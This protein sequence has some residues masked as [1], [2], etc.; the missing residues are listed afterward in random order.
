MSQP[1]PASPPNDRKAQ[2]IVATIFYIPH[3]PNLHPH[4]HSD[5]ILTSSSQ[6]H[7]ASTS[8]ANNST[9]SFGTSNSNTGN[10]NGN[11]YDY[12]VKSSNSTSD[13]P[14]P[15]VQPGTAPTTDMDN[16]PLEPPTPGPE[17]LDHLYGPY[18]SAT[19]LTHFYRMLAGIVPGFNE[20]KC[21]TKPMDENISQ[22]RVVEVTFEVP[23][24]GGSTAATTTAAGIADGSLDMIVDSPTGAMS[25]DA[26]MSMPNSMSSQTHT[27]TTSTAPSAP[28]QSSMTSTSTS[29]SPPPMT[30]PPS[31]DEIRRD[32]LISRFEQ[33]WDV[34]IVFQSSSVYRT[35]KRLAVFDMD[36]TLIQQ[37]VIDEVARMAGVLPAV[38]A[39]TTRAMNGDIDFEAS[40]RERCRLLKGVGADVW[41]KLQGSNSEGTITLTPGAVELVRCLKR[42]GYKTAVLSG[43]FMPMATW[44]AEK[45]GLDYAYANNLE[46]KSNPNNTSFFSTTSTSTSNT[47][48]HDLNNV[49]S[50]S[51]TA[52]LT[53]ELQGP[54]VDAAR[55]ANLVR[56]LADKED[57]L[58]SQTLVVG[59]GANDLPMM[60]LAGLGLAFN[61]KSR[62]QMEA[63]ARLNSRSLMD[64]LYLLGLGA[65]EQ[66]ELL[67]A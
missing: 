45:L 61:A 14:A 7:L 18:V 42:L 23:P 35:H 52:T 12:S 29:S 5:T 13:L 22:P 30:K 4:V 34:E 11:G 64:V 28:T 8:A 55:K 15:C 38:A 48:S 51:V 17:P 9:I 25:M 53:G 43:G 2:K 1:D 54:I 21:V 60:A 65:A 58:L 3:S 66:R 27:S 62:V 32:E 26:V 36:S 57:V 47:V 40:L 39:I 63:P 31:L 10:G 16:Y 44:L 19:C 46:T 50:R 41:E 37:E 33:E 56:T 6:T 24:N 67:E 49:D 20:G 59:D